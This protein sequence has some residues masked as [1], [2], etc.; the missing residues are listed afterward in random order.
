MGVRITREQFS[1]V[2]EEV[3]YYERVRRYVFDSLIVQTPLASEDTSEIVLVMKKISLGNLREQ[4]LCIV[5]NAVGTV[6]N[7]WETDVEIEE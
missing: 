7:T 6:I 2:Q 4:N 1:Q 3:K 5:I